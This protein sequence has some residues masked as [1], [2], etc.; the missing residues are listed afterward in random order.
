MS[1]AVAPS[2]PSLARHRRTA[3]RTAVSSYIAARAVLPGVSWACCDTAFTLQPDVNR[4]V[5]TAHQ[6][7]LAALEEKLWHSYLQPSRPPQPATTALQ[8]SSSSPSP[9][10]SPFRS[11]RAPKGTS[12]S[13]SLNCDCNG[14]GLVLLFYKYIR[15]TDLTSLAESQQ[16]LCTRLNLTGKIRIAHEGV[17]VTVAGA[18]ADVQSYIAEMCASELL[19]RNKDLHVGDDDDVQRNRRR[20]FKPSAGCAHV[21]DGLS[22]RIVDEVCPFGVKDYTPRDLIAA[23]AANA[24]LDSALLTTTTTT[25]RPKSLPPASFHALLTHAI[26]NRQTHIILDT[27]NEYEHRLGHF[28][29]ATCPPIR[30]FADLP[31]YV[32]GQAPS[33]W[34]GKTVLT[35]CTGGVRCEKAARWIGENVEGVEGVVMLEG[36]IH[37]YFE[38][39][40]ER[41]DAAA[42][43]EEQEVTTTTEQDG[44]HNDDDDDNNTDGSEN[45]TKQQQ[46]FKNLFQGRNYVFDARQSLAPS[47]SSSSSSSSSSPPSSL[48]HTVIT[49]C[50]F[51]GER[52]AR[53]AKCRR[54]GC[55]LMLT[56]CSECEETRRR[57]MVFC[58]AKCQD[59]NENEKQIAHDVAA[60]ATT[61]AIKT[62][63]AKAP[64]RRWWCEC[65]TQRREKLYG[66]AGEK[67]TSIA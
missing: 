22:V 36:G 1:P 65:E 26:L 16:T 25:T 9:S 33:F 44:G 40:K 17:N 3:R 32:A 47:L 11:R 41:Q 46:P 67:K 53:Y 49:D 64:R 35:Y 8:S 52:T 48:S 15:I 21:F 60:A 7:E 62:T 19:L 5:Q 63:T 61:T 4:H 27:R 58:C 29:N 28:T 31:A 12:D 57:G 20:F 59:R 50:M 43:G 51:C 56:C 45:A 2:P 66:K 39:V 34:R 13:I 14:N 42:A 30:R 23:A 10:P 37:N 6:A 18:R 38:W 54:A 24:E 55:H